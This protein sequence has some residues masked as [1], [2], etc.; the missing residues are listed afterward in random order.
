ML[1]LDHVWIAAPFRLASTRPPTAPCKL[2]A[3]RYARGP[4]P[5]PRALPALSR[6][7]QHKHGARPVNFG[8]EGTNRLRQLCPSPRAPH[9]FA[10][11]PHHTP[12]TRTARPGTL[13]TIKRSASR[14]GAATPSRRAARPLTAAALHAPLPS[15]PARAWTAAL[16][17]RGKGRASPSPRP[18]CEARGRDAA[19]GGG[20]AV[21]GR[22]QPMGTAPG[23]AEG[24]ARRARRWVAAAPPLL[25]NRSRPTWRAAV[26]E[27]GHRALSAAAAGGVSSAE[28]LPAA[29]LRSP[30]AL[31]RGASPPTRRAGRPLSFPPPRAKMAGGGRW[32]ARTTGCRPAGRRAGAADRTGA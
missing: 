28:R 21:P 13:R 20:R 9:L 25:V 23:G 19:G 2:R 8:S 16:Y 27:R 7:G 24:G 32:A 30:P 18:P 22:R 1:C 6:T 11:G 31:G 15:R 10:A 14:H 17:V 29:P 12:R 3:P 5:A 4:P 26:P